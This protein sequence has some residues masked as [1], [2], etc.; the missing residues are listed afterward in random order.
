MYM[1]DIFYL[2]LRWGYCRVLR[3]MVTEKRYWS[4]ADKYRIV[5]ELTKPEL[6]DLVNRFLKQIFLESLVIGN[7]TKQASINILL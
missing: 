5:D 2:F 3:W 6:M 4:H 1:P 7:F